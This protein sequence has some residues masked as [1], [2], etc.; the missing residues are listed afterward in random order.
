MRSFFF[1]KMFY[2]FL[3]SQKCAYISVAFGSFA[4][5]PCDL[6]QA[7]CMCFHKLL[8]IV[9]RS[10]GLFLLT[11]LVS[12]SCVQEAPLLFLGRR[13]FSPQWFRTLLSASILTKTFA[14]VLIV[15]CTFQTKAHSSLGH[16][17]HLLEWCDGWTFLWCLF[18][19]VIVGTNEE[20]MSIIIWAFPNYFSWHRN[21]CVRKL[22][23]LKKVINLS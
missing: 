22:L 19:W 15:I 5:E 18:I 20:M 2:F 16:R 13:T 12:L 23:T 3:E 6:A 10:F 9:C 1:Q 21:L 7:F 4:F 11:E 8:A 14:F 17:S